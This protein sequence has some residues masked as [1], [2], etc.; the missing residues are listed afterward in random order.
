CVPARAVSAPPEPSAAACVVMHPETGRV[1]YERSA[2]E[3]LPIASTTKIMTA[4]V[5][6]GQCNPDARVRILPE[7]TDVEGSS[8]GLRA[9]ETYTVEQL[10]YGLMLC[11]GNDAALAL[12]RFAGG[13]VEG[14]ARLMNGKAA[15]LGLTRTHFCN[16][17]GLD[18][19]GHLSTARDLAALSCAAMDDPR[20]RAIV[21]TA[22]YACGDQIYVNHNKLL[23]TYP[24]AIGVK[25]GYTQAAGR[26]LVSCAERNGTRFVCVTIDD[27]ADWDAELGVLIPLRCL[28]LGQGLPI[29]LKFSLGDHA[30]NFLKPRGAVSGGHTD[31]SFSIVERFA[32]RGFR[33]GPSVPPHAGR[34]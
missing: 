18:E 28:E 11:S 21:S 27:P 34:K 16:P 12:A 30:V 32:A 25:T 7:D 1:L 5:V 33:P 17:H 23:N 31:S 3:R 24:G 15:A 8:M 29:V 20:F 2:D 14:F 10:L 22:Q 6:L 13:G 19:E 26:I 9:G 4:L